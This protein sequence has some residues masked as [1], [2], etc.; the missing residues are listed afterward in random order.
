MSLVLESLP[1]VQ[2]KN[3]DYQE[4]DLTIRYL[5]LYPTQATLAMEKKLFEL[6]TDEAPIDRDVR[7]WEYLISG[8]EETVESSPTATPRFDEVAYIDLMVHDI[9]PGAVIAGRP[10][11]INKFGLDLISINRNEIPNYHEFIGKLIDAY[12]RTVNIR[13]KLNTFYVERAQADGE[14]INAELTSAIN[15]NFIDK[16]R[17][18]FLEDNDAKS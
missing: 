10:D 3:P 7:L 11:I 14:Q 6:R 13:R 2:A 4:E 9:I 12:D 15:N 16:L 18:Q 5:R 8:Q 17:K 1:E